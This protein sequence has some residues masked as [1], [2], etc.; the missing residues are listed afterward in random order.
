M[1][2]ARRVIFAAVAVLIALSTATAGLNAAKPAPAPGGPGLYT[3]TIKN[4]EFTPRDLTIAPGSKIT[5]VNK[6]EE[7]HKLSEVNS[8]FASQPLDTDGSFTYEFKAAG[9]FE[10]F[11]TLH[12]RM[13]GHIVVEGK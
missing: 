8:T 1:K 10:Y 4:F 2:Y 6:D 5:W 7:P 3:I 13:T 11:C 9:R 12:P